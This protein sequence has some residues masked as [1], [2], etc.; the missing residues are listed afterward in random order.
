MQI[1]HTPSYDN[2]WA[3]CSHDL[4][5][6]I[7]HSDL[8]RRQLTLEQHIAVLA[9]VAHQEKGNLTYK[10]V[11]TLIPPLNLYYV[12]NHLYMK[13]QRGSGSQ[14]SKGCL[15]W[16]SLDLHCPNENSLVRRF[17]PKR[18]KVIQAHRIPSFPCC[19]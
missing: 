17:G 12:R 11:S 1:F 18:I 4:T 8:T 9:K 16:S 10:G 7:N 5:L 2:V 6:T 15:F 14:L 3:H 13:S 19:S